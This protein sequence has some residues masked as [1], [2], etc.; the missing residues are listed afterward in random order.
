V[1]R[2]WL[3]IELRLW[4]RLWLRIR[5]DLLRP[6]TVAVAGGAGF[7]LPNKL[8]KNPGLAGAALG[9]AEGTALTGGGVLIYYTI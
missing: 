8:A 9:V 3:R 7:L 4:L 6:P 2:L 1:L 5:I